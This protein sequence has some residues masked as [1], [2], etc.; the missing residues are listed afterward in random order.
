MKIQTYHDLK[1]MLERELSAITKKGE[2]NASVLDMIDKLTH[3]IKSISTVVAMET[4]D[5]GESGAYPHYR[6]GRSERRDNRGRFSRKD[7]RE[8]MID[9]LHELANSTHDESMRKKL[10]RFISEIESA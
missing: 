6:Y 1:D 10:H 5:D 4:Y 8:D 2:L 3:S 7:A 9:D